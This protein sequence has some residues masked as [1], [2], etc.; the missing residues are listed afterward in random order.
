MRNGP[1]TR[2]HGDS[3]GQQVFVAVTLLSCL[4]LQRFALPVGG[5][6]EMSVAAP[7][8]GVMT[9]WFLW[10]GVLTID[11]SRFAIMLGLAGIALMAVNFRVSMPITMVTKSSFNSLLFWL[12]ITAFAILRFAEPMDERVFYSMFIRCLAFIAVC[13]VAAFLVQFVGLQLFSFKDWL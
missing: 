7:I 6:T 9:L 2:T 13:G 8:V 4:V 3:R 10:T 1:D 5:A 12:G 11:R